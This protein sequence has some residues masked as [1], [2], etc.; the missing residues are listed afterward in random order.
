MRGYLDGVELWNEERG[1]MNDDYRL[2]NWRRVSFIDWGRG[3]K[4][5]SG[6]KRT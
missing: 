3:K 6:M 5:I 1:R 2:L 4:Q